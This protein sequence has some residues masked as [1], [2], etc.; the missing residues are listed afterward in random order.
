[1]GRVGELT[2][3]EAEEHPHLL[4]EKLAT[5]LGLQV[6]PVG[7]DVARRL[8]EPRL[9]G[10]HRDVVVDQLAELGRERLER[11]ARELGPELHTL[12]HPRSWVLLG[13]G[14]G[15]PY[16]ETVTRDPRVAPGGRRRRRRR[17]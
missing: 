11:D 14:H 12:D 4:L 8:L 6:E 9:P 17:S 13:V 1:P 7:V 5:F 16:H 3:L 2:A 10:L 15:R